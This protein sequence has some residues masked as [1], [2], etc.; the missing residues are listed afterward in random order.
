MS[1]AASSLA[2]CLE[3][4]LQFDDHHFTDTKGDIVF[5]KKILHPVGIAHDNAS[6]RGIGRFRDAE[7][8]DIDVMGIEQLHDLEHGADFVR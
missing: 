3:T 7:R 2:S 1:R 5:T 4:S 8:H 6:D